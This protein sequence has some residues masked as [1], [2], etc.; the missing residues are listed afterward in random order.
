LVTGT[1]LII[2]AT[3]GIGNAAAHA[4]LAGGWA[5]R[6]LNRDPVA[7]SKNFPRL[8]GIEWIAGDALRADDVAR[9]ATGSRV[10]VHAANPPGY[11]D[12]RRL[13]VPML[14]NAIAAARAAEARLV[15]PGNIYNFDPNAGPIIGE[16]TPQAPH[17]WQL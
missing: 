2:G 15:F 11:K 4:L 17:S 6:A 8:Q 16:D 1:A 10:I 3:G 13:A 7:A 5:L 14:A 12:W 9:A